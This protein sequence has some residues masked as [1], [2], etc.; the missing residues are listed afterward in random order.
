MSSEGAPPAPPKGSSEACGQIV[1]SWEAQAKTGDSNRQGGAQ[2]QP[3]RGSGTT[4]QSN[5]ESSPEGSQTRPQGRV[6]VSGSRVEDPD[7]AKVGDEIPDGAEECA[8]VSPK[9]P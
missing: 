1:A 4:G 5:G 3:S 7:L 8:R 6:E 9:Y 2:K